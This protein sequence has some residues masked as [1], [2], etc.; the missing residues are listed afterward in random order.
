MSPMT[1][2]ELL[3]VAAVMLLGGLAFVALD[4]GSWT[5]WPQLLGVLVVLVIAS[6]A[7]PIP[8]GWRDDHH[9]TR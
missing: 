5:P 9:R 8:F 4:Y 2:R 3:R 6:L 1:R 7:A